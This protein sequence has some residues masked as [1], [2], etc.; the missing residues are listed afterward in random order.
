MTGI[1]VVGYGYWGPNLVRN[2]AEVPDCQV[3]GVS[4]LR[5]ERLALV[6]KRYPA[7]EAMASSSD[8]ISHPRVDAVAIAT[9][10]STHFELG[11]QALR[12]G[13]H[14]LIEKPLAA[15]SEQAIQLI[16]EATR[17]KL[18]LM[19]DHTFV[20]TSAVRKIQELVASNSLGQIYY[21]DSVRVNLGLFQHDVNVIWDLAVH[22]LSIM[23]YI[24][25]A[26]PC[27]V[28]ATGISHVTGKPEN[29]AYLTLFFDGNLIAHIHANWLAPVKVRR[30]LIGGA[31]RMIVYDDLEPSEKIKV[32]DKGITL[33]GST[34]STYQMM[35]GYRTGDMW[36]P[37]LEMTETLRV[38]AGHF[39]RCIED[40]EPV[41]TDGETGLRVVEILE[42]ATSSLAERGRPVELGRKRAMA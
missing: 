32:Y 13:K 15:S 11:M 27:A 5:P 7:V 21:Y 20:Y 3:V 10:V 30:T 1:G 25:P 12:A 40:K 34:E 18:V 31:R 19:V 29:L 22:D 17:R 38:E 2:F 16:E 35:I 9:P 4:D 41:I 24:L 14:V 42:A 39:I 33:S 6:R 28:S 8:L 36:A 26:R 37:N 23:D